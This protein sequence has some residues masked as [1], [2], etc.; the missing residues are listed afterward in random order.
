MQRSFDLFEQT[1][2]VI[3]A[4]SGTNTTKIMRLDLERVPRRPCRTGREPTPQR[5][6]DH[7]P[8]AAAR[9]PRQRLELGCGVFVE[10][11]GGAHTV[12]LAMRHHDVNVV[13]A[14]RP[15][16]ISSI[17]NRSVS[18]ARRWIDAFRL[19]TSCELIV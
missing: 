12:M 19:S 6:V 9:S 17:R 10:C 7:I 18:S 11:Q 15:F 2:D 1:A 8:E 3:E 13:P 14:P 5:I 4:Q 16:R